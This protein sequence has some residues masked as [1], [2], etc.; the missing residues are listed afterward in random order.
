MHF[1]LAVAGT[2]FFFI[3]KGFYAA[4]QGIVEAFQIRDN[5]KKLLLAKDNSPSFQYY[6]NDDPEMKRLFDNP[7]LRKDY[8]MLMGQEIWYYRWG[9]FYKYKI[10]ETEEEMEEERN[11]PK[12]KY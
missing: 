7:D 11:N 5:D 3:C 6:L 10:C 8:F 4:I 1:L 2:I 12:C 9:T